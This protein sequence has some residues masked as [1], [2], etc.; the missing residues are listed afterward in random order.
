MMR[1]LTVVSV[2]LLFASCVGEPPV[3]CT[4]CGNDCVDTRVDPANCGACG[5]ACGAG[6]ICSAGSCKD[7]CPAAEKSCG[8]KC[9]DTQ[10]DPLNCGACGMNCGA[11]MLC[12]AGACA[13]SCPAT[14]DVCGSKC[15]D[16]QLD[17]A[18]CGMCGMACTAGQLC[19]AGA[20]GATCAAPLVACNGKCVNVANDPANC[21]GCG[22][23]CNP[24]NT[25]A[26]V[27]VAG[28]CGYTRCSNGFSDCDGNPLN[29]C[30][31]STGSDVYNCGGCALVCLP[32]NVKVKPPPVPD[33]GTD[34]GVD[35][36]VDAGTD[37][38]VI[39]AG[40][41]D[42]GQ[43][44]GPLPDGGTLG[45][46]YPPSG[47]VCI[48]SACGYEQCQPGFSDC[49]GIPANG[50]ET[51]V[52]ASL[53]HCGGCN[54]KCA[55][56]DGVCVDGVCMVD[57]PSY[58]FPTGG[59]L[60]P[61]TEPAFWQGGRVRPV[62][63]SFAAIPPATLYYTTNG[64][65][66]LAD[67]GNGTLSAANVF[68]LPASGD[69]YVKWFAVYGDG[70][71]EMFTQ[72][73]QQILNAASNVTAGAIAENVQHLPGNSPLR[74]VDAG[75]P[76]SFSVAIQSWASGPG[77]YCP[78]CVWVAGLGLD[79][80]GRI[81]CESPVGV[82]P[83]ASSTPTINTTAPLLPGTYYIRYGIGAVFNCTMLG[84]GGEPAGVVIVR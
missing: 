26:S 27:C 9:V 80:V 28:T 34:A 23:A 74:V 63:L 69:V 33:G 48:A 36:G 55:G 4:K 70:R 46:C 44:C 43:P 47:A 6:K 84:G 82:Y 5:T 11:G 54:V 25:T 45:R 56:P 35:A 59:Q 20:C 10:N 37:A 31:T 51:N 19:S 66:P 68:K 7:N 24:T 3:P 83:G 79:G 53:T 76:L 1:L 41:P 60:F 61:L 38:G 16:K 8:G 73:Y 15:V 12:V 64:A 14:Q 32:Q 42:A 49:D 30:E 65:E 75:T 77:G 21:G 62:T 52:K 78:G 67:G 18:N 50:C 29:G 17:P 40:V 72:T 39:D 58:H 57:R 2:G 22:T 13:S 71:R 81:D